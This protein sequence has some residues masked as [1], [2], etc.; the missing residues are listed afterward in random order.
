[1]TYDKEQI[2]NMLANAPIDSSH[3]CEDDND[4]L[5]SYLQEIGVNDFFNYNNGATKFVLIPKDEDKD[6]VI[7]AKWAKIPEVSLPQTGET[8]SDV[9]IVLWTALTLVSLGFVTYIIRRFRK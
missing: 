2:L 8:V 6:Y 9:L 5:I 4:D 7:K 3:F 1:M